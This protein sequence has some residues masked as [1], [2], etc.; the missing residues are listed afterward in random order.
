MDNLPRDEYEEMVKQ[1]DVGLVL[2]DN[3]FTIPNYPS[4]ILSYMEFSM[5][6]LAATDTNTDFKDLINES[7][8]GLWCCSDNV[9]EFCK[10]AILLSKDVK[11]RKKMG[12]KGREYLEENFDVSKSI[13]LIEKYI[14]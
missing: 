5:P 8:C 12:I 10:N 14:R 7:G 4:R 9:N 11:L 6:V 3:R 2:L 1:C 13:E